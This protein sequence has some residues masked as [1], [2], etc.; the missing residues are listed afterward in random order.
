VEGFAVGKTADY[1]LLIDGKNVAGTSYFDVLNPATEEVVARAPAA[2]RHQLDEAVAAARRA[3]PGWRATPIASRQASVAA[4]ADVIEA[5]IDELKSLLTAEQGKTLADAG[6][7]LFGGAHFCR[8][9]GALTPPVEVHEDSD[10]RLSVTNHVPLGVVCAIA[11]WN[12][13]VSL[14]FWKVAPALVAGNTVVLKPSPFTPLTTLRIAELVRDMLPPGVL[15]VLSGGD[16]LGPWMTGHPGFNKISFTGSTATGRKVMESAAP[17]LKRLTLELGG[18]DAAIVLPGVD[19]P[20]AARGV[21]YGAFRNSGQICAAAKRVYVHAD[22]YD[23]FAAE[24]VSLGR[25]AKV[26]NGV[27]P[28]TAFG[29]IQNRPQYERVKELIADCKAQGHRFLLGGDA[30]M[31]ERGYFVPLTI[32]DNPPAESRIAREEQ[33]GP[34]MPLLRYDDIDTVIAEANNTD[35]GLGASVWG[36]SEAALQVA[37]QLE[38]GTVWI[39]EI[40]AIAPGQPFGG[41]KQSG[42]G[43][44]NGLGG[45]LEFTCV[46]SIVSAR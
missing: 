22:V 30:E 2:S 35:F 15:N 33:F 32:L 26:G 9:F 18:N 36:P 27:D 46:Q 28:D 1:Q 5:H 4:L 19:V 39:N 40:H 14:A 3:F 21:F 38:A 20:S 34:I 29:P 45:L 37:Q 24:I 43:I 11:P 44:E 8:A 25:Q 13:P 23:A 16:E 41:Q 10:K 42:F 12:Q 17:T 31:P 6:M 7:E